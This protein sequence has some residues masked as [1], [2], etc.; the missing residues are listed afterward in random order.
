MYER[1]LNYYVME[2]IDIERIE[3]AIYRMFPYLNA[4]RPYQIFQ[5]LDEYA[6]KR[7]KC[8]SIAYFPSLNMFLDKTLSFAAFIIASY[9]LFSA[10]SEHPLY[11]LVKKV[12]SEYLNPS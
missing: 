10:L 3:S 5:F 7:D 2:R 4:L 6:D 9:L 11:P 1:G 8:G 12:E